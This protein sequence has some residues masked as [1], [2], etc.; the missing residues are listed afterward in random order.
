MDPHRAAKGTLVAR[1]LLAPYLVFLGLVVFLPAR[2]AR[3]VTGLVG[4]LA[5]VL[6]GVG[7]PRE[8]AAVALEL[9]ANVALFTPLGLLV[10]L[11]VPG[12]R[13]WVV[14]ATGLLLSTGIEL[15]Q[16]ALPSRV[17]T[18]SDVIANTAGT[19]LGLVLARSTTRAGGGRRGAGRP[20]AGQYAPSARTTDRTVR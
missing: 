17:S 12:A 5:D 15:V 4:W 11:A 10:A 14:I 2:E 8:P 3:R 19:A 6:A 1:I 20:H 16:L 7:I 13:W 18:V 9:L